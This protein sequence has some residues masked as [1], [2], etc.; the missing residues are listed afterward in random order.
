M[1]FKFLTARVFKPYC[2]IRK[3]EMKAGNDELLLG[4][5]S[6]SD[7]NFYSSA[8]SRILQILASGMAT[9]STLEAFD[10]KI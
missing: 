4:W 8:V 3:S 6:T 2:I 9:R 7:F 1:D 10:S 5:L